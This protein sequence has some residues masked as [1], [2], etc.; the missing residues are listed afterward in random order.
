LADVA[1][2]LGRAVVDE[3]VDRGRELL[4]EGEAESSVAR[5]RADYAMR[6]GVV[7]EERVQS[8]LREEMRKDLLRELRGAGYVDREELEDDVFGEYPDEIVEEEM[9]RMWKQS[10]VS[11]PSADAIR[12]RT[13]PRAMD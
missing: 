13:D 8:K 3:V 4:R 1:D 7:E 6:F 5:K 10:V 9:K 11:R 2:A 12:L